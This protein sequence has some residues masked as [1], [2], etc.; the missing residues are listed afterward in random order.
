MDTSLLSIESLL[1][2][3]YGEVLPDGTLTM[4][5]AGISSVIRPPEAA[6][7]LVVVGT[8]LSEGPVGA[9]AHRL[10]CKLRDPSGVTMM[11]MSLDVTVEGGV[12]RRLPVCLPLPL[13]AGMTPGEWQVELSGPEELK[14]VTLDVQQTPSE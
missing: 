3:R 11:E 13:P 10:Y 9:N 14:V 5:G 6:T 8:L 1:I 12:R 7:Q 2:A 4:V